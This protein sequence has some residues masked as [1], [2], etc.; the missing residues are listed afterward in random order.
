MKK[1]LFIAC[2]VALLSGNMVAQTEISFEQYGSLNPG[3]TKWYDNFESWQPG[4]IIDENFFVSR[5]RP[6][7]RFFNAN[8]Q[9]YPQLDAKGKKV[10]WW[11]PISNGNWSLNM[12]SHTMRNDNFSLWSYIDVH[13]GWNQPMINSSGT[14]SDIC[15]KNGVR[16]TV[17]MFFDQIGSTIDY[18][19]PAANEPS[20]YFNLLF[21]KDAKGKFVNVEKFIKMFRYYGIGGWSINPESS[22]TKATAD[23]LQDFMVACHQEAEKLGWGDQWNICWYDA[24]N[25]EGRGYSW[26]LNALTSDRI[27]WFA[28]RED[29]SQKV[30][31]HFFLNYNHSSGAINKSIDNAKGKGRSSYDVYVGQHIGTRGLGDNWQSIIESEI[32]IGT[33]GEHSQNNIFYNS[34]DKGSAPQTQAEVY[35]EKLEMF[36]SGGNRNPKNTPA[37][38][39]SRGD[40]SYDSFQKFNGLSKGVVAQSTLTQL[41]FIT[42]FSLG[43]GMSNYEQGEKISEFQWYNIGMQ[44]HMPTWRWWIVDDTNSV[45]A[46]PIKCDLSFDEA[47]IGANSLKLSGATSKSNVRLFKT[48][49]AVKG[50]ENLSLIYKT[51]GST[52]PKMKLIYSIVGEESNFKS[53]V[54]PVADAADK[55]SKATWKLSD[56]GIKNGDVIACLGVSLENTT[57]NYESY[58]G[59]ISLVDP[60]KTFNPVKPILVESGY[61]VKMDKS[62]YNFELVKLIWNS[63][64]NEDIWTPVYNDD[65]DTWYFEVM[66]RQDGGE[67]KLVN[68][69][70]SWATVS[71][72]QL[73]AT[74]RTF[75]VGVRAVA[76]DGVTRSEISWYKNIFD[77][78]YEY[79][80]GI[81]YD[82]RKLIP[83]EEF[84][85]SLED[86]TIP[87]AHWTLTDDAGTVVY[88]TDGTSV[89]TSCPKVGLYNLTVK[90]DNPTPEDPSAVYEFTYDAL[91]Q[92]TPAETGRFPQANFDF[93]NDVDI[94][95]GAQKV[96]FNFNG[97][98]G[99]GYTSNAVDI[100]NGTYFFAAD[101]AV[102]GK[103]NTITLAA[104]VKPTQAIGQV[105]SLRDL[106]TNPSWGSTWIY[107]EENKTNGNKREFCL[108]GRNRHEDFKDMFSGVEVK[109]GLWYHICM[110]LDRDNQEVRLYING[111]KTN[112]QKV[113]FK[114]SY[115]LYALGTEGFQ[116]SID[117]VQFWNKALSDEEV[118]V[119]MYGYKPENIPSQLRGYWI[120]EERMATNEKKFP[121]LGAAGDAYPAAIFK[122]TTLQDKD[123]IAPIM[124]PGSTWLSGTTPLKA[125]LTWEFEGAANVDLSDIENPVVTYDKEGEHIAKLTVTND[126]GSHAK[127]V[128]VKVVNSTSVSSTQ[129]ASIRVTPTEV[130]DRI[131]VQLIEKGDY[132]IN[133][134]NVNGTLVKKINRSCSAN[135][136]VSINMD[137]PG[138][139]YF[140]KVISND[141]S[142]NMTRIVKK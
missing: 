45:P 111:K 96:T 25:N 90:F 76:P 73:D 120:F 122:G 65:V 123:N 109:L 51:K 60:A 26:G 79:K 6:Q 44:D 106:G 59:G 20:K 138:G 10:L 7:N 88:E 92:V 125:T 72:I 110:V 135:E 35:T 33:W 27:N 142:V 94:T 95:D 28:Y 17:V 124:V 15:H 66:V 36:F 102:L 4:Q 113:S 41:P 32:S 50:N 9:V 42:Y 38:I 87:T 70:T 53:V 98:K 63:K 31:D 12:P 97:V 130:H 108:M 61:D 118:K 116:G 64:T 43:N 81:V 133:I 107:I 40:L 137:L 85:I 101:P 46:S 84:T 8:T 126:Y 78:K 37:Y 21:K 89:T 2:G 19:K 49:F 3:D 24:M 34:T 71:A 131:D 74:C 22:M 132:Q 121:N 30:V 62:A 86:P 103:P 93:N 99:E 69:T 119:A 1:N 57:S 136:I 18:T 128:L 68:R 91:V 11:M 5:V 77:H 16:N 115:D 141:I 13:G 39:T 29:P 54:V 52:E 58:I 112:S 55:W 48:K 117:E 104:W 100:R 114:S 47:Y 14:F 67:P 139:V 127:S 105:L 129:Q 80:T 75:E 23:M 82:A 83:S 56:C 134:Y 140:V